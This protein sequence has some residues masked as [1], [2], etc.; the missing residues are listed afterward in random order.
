MSYVLDN[1]KIADQI[2]KYICNITNSESFS[3]LPIKDRKPA[4]LEQWLAGFRDTDF[5]VTD[6]FHACVFSIIFRKPFIV[7][8]NATRGTSRIDSLL[9]MFELRHHLINDVSQIRNLERYN[10]DD[11]KISEILNREKQKSVDFLKNSLKE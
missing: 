7:V 2:L 8:S 11:K 5:I 10:L 1:N 9:E 3:A 6:S 4:S